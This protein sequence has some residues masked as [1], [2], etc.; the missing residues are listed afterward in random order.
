MSAAQEP[1][2]AATRAISDNS[3]RCPARE[4]DNRGHN[5]GVHACHSI[6]DLVVDRS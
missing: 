1:V 6:K 2:K 3:F 4:V 5:D